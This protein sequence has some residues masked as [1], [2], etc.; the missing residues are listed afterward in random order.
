MCSVRAK[1]VLP[2]LGGL[3]ALGLLTLAWAIGPGSSEAQQDAM[4][5]CPQAGKWAISA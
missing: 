2:L 4:Y 5:N 3:V 1:A